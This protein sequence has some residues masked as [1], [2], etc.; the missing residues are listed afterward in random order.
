[1]P[2]PVRRIDANWLICSTF[3]ASA[4]KNHCSM[5]DYMSRDHSTKLLVPARTDRSVVV[6][7]HRLQNSPAA[8]S[9]SAFFVF[10]ASSDLFQT[11]RFVSASP[12]FFL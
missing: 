8:N 7:L 9:S 2:A 5:V 1:M 10:F 11:Y 6:P 12:H 3:R 4:V